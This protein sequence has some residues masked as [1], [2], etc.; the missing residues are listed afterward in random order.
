MILSNC[1]VSKQ[2][3]SVNEHTVRNKTLRESVHRGR[4]K[5]KISE[6]KGE[7]EEKQKVT[8]QGKYHCYSSC[9]LD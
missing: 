7:E 8:V 3:Y 4:G 2:N 5:E 1:L 6:A 9:V